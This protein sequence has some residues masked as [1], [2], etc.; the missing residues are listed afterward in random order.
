M[1]FP[2]KVGKERRAFVERSEPRWGERAFLREIIQIDI[3][4]LHLRATGPAACGTPLVLAYAAG[5]SGAPPPGPPEPVFMKM[6]F[7]TPAQT[8]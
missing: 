5:D 6:I 7:L 8:I 1:V 3:L 4:S 2:T